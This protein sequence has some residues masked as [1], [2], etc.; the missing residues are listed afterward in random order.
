MRVPDQN[1]LP[2]ISAPAPKQSSS[3]SR[4]SADDGSNF[5]EVYKKTAT[6]K[7]RSSEQASSKRNTE[8]SGK[9]DND[10]DQVK[11]RD[12]AAEKNA[13]GDANAA[14]NKAEGGVV[15]RGV[16]AAEKK[17]LL[18]ALADFNNMSGNDLQKLAEELGLNADALKA[19][20]E[21]LVKSAKTTPTGTDTAVSPE[22]SAFEEDSVAALFRLLLGQKKA[23]ENAN[24]D[25]VS[26][27]ANGDG[28]ETP[29]HVAEADAKSVDD[30][31]DLLK[32]LSAEM[33]VQADDQ[34]EK[35]DADGAGQRVFRF[36]RADG[37][38]VPV[39]MQIGG[40]Q[41]GDTLESGNSSKIETVTVL[42][43]RRYL[44][45]ADINTTNIVSNMAGDKGWASA[46]KTASSNHVAALAPEKTIT[47]VN[48]LKIQMHPVDLGTVTATLRLKGD[49]LVVN[50]KVHTAEAYN[51]LTIDKD[52][53]IQSL[54][55]QGFSVD[56]INIQLSATPDRGVQQSA[57]SQQQQ[58][59]QQMQGGANGEAARQGQQDGSRR[60]QTGNQDTFQTV[61]DL[62][63]AGGDVSSDGRKAGSGQIYL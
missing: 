50:M 42:D 12:A 57:A 25:K 58:D 22:A 61:D 45:P 11:A 7:D 33:K 60:Q 13:P 46:M 31:A 27:G 48:T 9:N 51:Q 44:A 34:T 14:A 1:L 36:E 54:K 20:L 59:G 40:Q 29:Q 52:K 39:E 4:R 3:A 23:S 47:E 56:H 43:A 17:A 19:A 30:I 2:A 18:K 24:A 37:K 63:A 10:N 16:K 15:D 26:N 49:D 53:I 35:Q 62:V 6:E 41:T 5:G 38:G 28:E 55:A 21:E 8:A 32:A